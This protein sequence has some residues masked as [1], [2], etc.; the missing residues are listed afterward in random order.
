MDARGSAAGEPGARSPIY[1][2]ARTRGA[3]DSDRRGR[4][5]HRPRLI[6]VKCASARQDRRRRRSRFFFFLPLLSVISVIPCLHLLVFIFFFSTIPLSFI[7]VFT[8]ARARVPASVSIGRR[9]VRHQ[10]V[11]ATAGN[12]NDNISATTISKIRGTK[13]QFLSIMNAAADGMKNGRGRRPDAR[14]Q[15][16]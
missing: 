5:T 9:P 2:R 12:R 16:R 11:R 8:R 3:R 1:A 13:T 15:Y 6:I 10:K 7:I 14:R 4:K